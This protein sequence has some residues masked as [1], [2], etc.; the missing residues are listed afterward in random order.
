MGNNKQTQI[1][2]D[3]TEYDIE[4]F[5]D[6][7]KILLE[8]CMDL[9]RKMNSCKYQLDQLSVGKDAFLGMLKKALEPAEV[10]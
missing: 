1:T 8:H 3:G 2:I 10:V 4:T 7:Q 9:D 6:Q 5:T